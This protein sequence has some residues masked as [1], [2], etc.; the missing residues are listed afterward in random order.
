MI[1]GLADAASLPE[2][3]DVAHQI[4]KCVKPENADQTLKRENHTGIFVVLFYQQCPSD[5]IFTWVVGRRDA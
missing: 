1:C 5:C 2:A 4:E 3:H